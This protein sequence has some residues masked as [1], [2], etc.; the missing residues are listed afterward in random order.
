MIFRRI[1]SIVLLLFFQTISAYNVGLLIVATGKYIE[2][3]KPLIE[4]AR[5]HF[6]KNHT[7][8]YFVFTDGVTDFLKS[9]DIVRLEQARLGWPKDTLMR[10]SIYEKHKDRY[11]TMDYLF[12]CD[13]DMRFEGEVG[14]EILSERVATLHPGYVGRRGEYET[15]SSSKAYVSPQEGVSYFCGGFNGGSCV[16]FLKMAHTI[17]QNIESDLEKK[18]IA[19]WHDESHINRYFIDHPPTK[20]LSPEYCYPDNDTH[21]KQGIWKQS[22]KRRLIAIDKNHAQYRT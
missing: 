4:S 8:T 22:Y 9:N 15:R 5:T 7:V 21:Y 14:D 13:A 16:E 1:Y 6:C 2:F 3:V 10:L 12:A 17:T 20:I 19:R 18:I 11:K